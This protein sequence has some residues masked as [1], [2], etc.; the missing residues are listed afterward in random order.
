MSSARPTARARPQP[1]AG[2]AALTGSSHACL[3]ARRSRRARAGAGEAGKRVPRF[4]VPRVQ[5]ERSAVLVG[6]LRPTTLTLEHRSEIEVQVRLPRVDLDRL[7]ELLGRL[8]DASLRGEG[9][10]ELV[11]GGEIA[12]SRDG[13]A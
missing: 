8:A 11:P 12:R 3:Y 10:T 9:R 13:V 6:R 1:S 7:P 2:S 4:P 5:A